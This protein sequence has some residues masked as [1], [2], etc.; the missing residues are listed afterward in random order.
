MVWLIALSQRRLLFDSEKVFQDQSF[1][2]CGDMTAI[3]TVDLKKGRC[4][5]RLASGIKGCEVEACD[6]IC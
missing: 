1:Q 3:M 4:L 5:D 6:K 2:L